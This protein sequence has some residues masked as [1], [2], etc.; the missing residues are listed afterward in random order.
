M[1]DLSVNTQD[2]HTRQKAEFP[3]THCGCAGVGN[4]DTNAPKMA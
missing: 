3:R 1:Q 4:Y 2:K